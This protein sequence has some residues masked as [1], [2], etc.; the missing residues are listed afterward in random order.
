MNSVTDQSRSKNSAVFAALFPDDPRFRV[1]LDIGDVRHDLRGQLIVT[2]L[3]MP[4]KTRRIDVTFLEPIA[5]R[6]SN[7]GTLL[8]YWSDGFKTNGRSLFVARESEFLDWIQQAS[9]GVYAA[10]DLSHYAV[11]S[12]DTCIEVLSMVPPTITDVGT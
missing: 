6:I 11:F 2:A 1:E 8:Q 4:E 9:H 10:K 12:D 5:T 7:E 3:V